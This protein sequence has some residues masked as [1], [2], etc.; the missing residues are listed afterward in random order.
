[1]NAHL[2]FRPPKSLVKYTLATNIL[3]WFLLV[4]EKSKVLL[5]SWHSAENKTAYRER[6]NELTSIILT[7]PH[8]S[9]SESNHHLFIRREN[10]GSK[11][12]FFLKKKRQTKTHLESG[13]SQGSSV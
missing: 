5:H 13:R 7:C 2:N 4:N 3:E 9:P 6:E 11:C 8:N 1:M 12:F 10:G